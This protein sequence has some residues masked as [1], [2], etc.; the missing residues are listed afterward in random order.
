[1]SKCVICLLCS[2]LRVLIRIFHFWFNFTF[3]YLKL[4]NFYKILYN[5]L[6][7]IKL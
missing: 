4:Y 7:N 5:S 3:K 1:M 2:S 6:I